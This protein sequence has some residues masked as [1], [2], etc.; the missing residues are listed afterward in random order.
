M[1]MFFLKN[2]VP[3][4]FL[5]SAC[6]TSPIESWTNLYSIRTGLE[7]K[8]RS[9]KTVYSFQEQ[10]TD[11]FTGVATGTWMNSYLQG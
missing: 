8:E 7:L 1:E 11:D 10:W 9:K 6:L 4:P 5:L 2:N 3:F